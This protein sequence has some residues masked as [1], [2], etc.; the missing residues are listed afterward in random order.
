M[1]NLELLD[2]FA[3]LVLP[4]IVSLHAGKN[5]KK[6]LLA[7]ESYE[8]AEAMLK[9]RKEARRRLEIADEEFIF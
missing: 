9:A 5:R 1:E 7:S 2:H 4:A 8:L 3:G 6:Q